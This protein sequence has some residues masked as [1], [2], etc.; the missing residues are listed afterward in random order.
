MD[1]PRSYTASYVTWQ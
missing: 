1:K